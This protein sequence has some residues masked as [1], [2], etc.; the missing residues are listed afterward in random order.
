MDYIITDA[1]LKVL[2]ERG[3]KQVIDE[4]FDELYYFNLGVMYEEDIQEYIQNNR[5]NPLLVEKFSKDEVE[6]GDEFRVFS[7]IIPNELARTGKIPSNLSD[8]LM[9]AIGAYFLTKSYTEQFTGR[10]HYAFR[11]S[12]FL[13]CIHDDVH[14]DFFL[15]QYNH[16][17]KKDLQPRLFQ[18]RSQLI[19]KLEEQD[20]GRLNGHYGYWIPFLTHLIYFCC[21]TSQEVPFKD[22]FNQ[23]FYNRQLFP[24]EPGMMAEGEIERLKYQGEED[25]KIKECL[26]E[27]PGFEKQREQGWEFRGEMEKSQ[28]FIINGNLV[29]CNLDEAGEIEFYQQKFK[30]AVIFTPDMIEQA[31]YGTIKSIING[32]GRNQ[33]Q[34]PGLVLKYFPYHNF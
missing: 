13:T 6:D 25:V 14:G 30:P 17:P 28:A 24:E 27:Y 15:Q 11:N 3:L 4:N 18:D 32:A 5:V 10:G 20:C 33:P 2:E 22:N 29:Y 8:D 19:K 31:I 16:V 9:T 26:P 34:D 23:V 7:Y 1:G 21:Q 12:Q